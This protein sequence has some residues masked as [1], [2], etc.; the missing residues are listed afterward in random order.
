MIATREC[1]DCCGPKDTDATFTFCTRC[2]AKRDVPPPATKDY[3][4]IGTKVR[5]QRFHGHEIWT[6]AH[7]G[8]NKVWDCPSITLR[9]A[10]VTQ[11][12]LSPT[13]DA[14]WQNWQEA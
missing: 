5:H 8:Y 4:A 2:S 13:A 12:V 11:T 9:C 6:V 1:P 14:F 10:T 7:V 3:P